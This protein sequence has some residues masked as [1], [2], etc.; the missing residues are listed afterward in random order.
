MRYGSGML[1]ALGVVGAMPAQADAIDMIC[2]GAGEAIH[3]D[4]GVGLLPEASGWTIVSTGEDLAEIATSDGTDVL[5]VTAGACTTEPEVG[6]VYALSVAGL[7]IAAVYGVQVSLRLSL[8]PV[9]APEGHVLFGL[10]DGDR[11]IAARIS[12]TD[13]AFVDRRTGRP[14]ALLRPRLR[15]TAAL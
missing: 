8:A 4:P 2:P 12:A 15:S 9:A 13:L 10:V 3:Y 14:I 6:L 5:R 1:V 11:A 7:D